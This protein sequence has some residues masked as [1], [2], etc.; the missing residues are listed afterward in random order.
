MNKHFIRWIAVGG[1]FIL[2]GLF[3]FYRFG[4]S[5]E[6]VAGP[7]QAAAAAGSTPALPVEAFIA[8]AEALADNIEVSGSTI[9]E[10][11]VQITSEIAGKVS[12]ILFQEGK[13]VE[14]GAILLRINDEEW[15]A[16]RE[17]L[18]VQKHLSEKIANRLK[19]LYEKEGVSLQEYEV[20]EAE[21]DRYDAEIKLMDVQLGKTVI[22]APFGGVM[23]L[24][25]ISEG[26]FVSPGTPIVSL[27][28]L[29]PIHVQFSIPEKYSSE[30]QVGG[31]ISCQLAGFEGELSATIV[32][33]DPRIDADTRTI[34]FE[35]SAP[36]PSGKVL[37]GA[38]TLVKVQLR[39][40]DKALLVPTEAVV[41][42]LGGKKLY[43]YRNGKAEGVPVVTGIRKDRAIQVAEGLQAG[44]TVITSGILQLRPGMPVSIKEIMTIPAVSGNR[45]NQ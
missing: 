36:N 25:K 30:L 31:R 26:S 3:L 11:E 18:V 12:A 24:R 33:R 6:K 32:A 44:D 8:K 19:A 34:T 22:R 16:Q 27:V 35:A 13:R 2:A 17:K 23:G 41:P 10:E 29:D 15:R 28:R 40:F 9:P 39:K 1:I 5:E 42:E 45:N 43:V 21:V 7:S 20:A 4:F 38:F 14:K 37:P